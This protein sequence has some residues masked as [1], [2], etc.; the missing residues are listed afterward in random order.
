MNRLV[1]ILTLPV[2]LIALVWTE[3]CGLGALLITAWPSTPLGYLARA[4]YWRRKTGVR[5][6]IV[7]RGARC[8]GFE[9]IRFGENLAIGENVEFVADGADGM[10]VFIGSNILFARGVYLR[11]SNHALEDRDRHIL[12]QGHVSKKVNHH[13]TDYAI[14]IDDESWIGANAII[15]SGAR[16]GR[17][18]VIGA[19]SVVAGD[20]PPYTI[21]GGVP[22]RVIGTRK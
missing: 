21:A 3:L 9:H 5:N 18:A 17:G 14:V 10:K 22:A 13:G 15:V 19:G 4:A 20:I 11:S 6:I 12:D 1:R 8:I 16:I 7:A 2:R